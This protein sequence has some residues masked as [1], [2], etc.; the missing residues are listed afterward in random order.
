M[1]SQIKGGLD[2]PKWRDDV[3]FMDVFAA[4]MAM[5]VELPVNGYKG[6]ILTC[7]V[8]FLEGGGS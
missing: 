6:R 2:P 3:R 7:Q 4:N 1:I 8:T 5:R